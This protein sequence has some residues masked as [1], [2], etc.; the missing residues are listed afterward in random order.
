MATAKLRKFGESPN[1]R[2]RSS[3]I[4][5]SGPPKGQVGGSSPPCGTIIKHTRR[6]M[7][8]SI[9]FKPRDTADNGLVSFSFENIRVKDLGAVLSRLPEAL[10]K[11]YANTV[12]TIVGPNDEAVRE[13]AERFILRRCIAKTSPGDTQSGQTGDGMPRKN[14]EPSPEES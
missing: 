4:G 14:E 9:K 12:A 5:Q 7:E 8:V 1:A 11:S 2:N 13:L 3:S 10:A 6:H